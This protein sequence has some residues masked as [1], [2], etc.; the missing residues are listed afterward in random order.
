[1]ARIVIVDDSVADL[2]MMT[3][4]LE[5]GH[6]SVTA[7]NNPQEAAERITAQQPQLVM[8]DVVMPV[9]NGY[10]VLRQL[11]RNPATQ[12]IPVILVSSKGTE[13]D[14]RWGL[15]QGASAYVTKP[16]TAEDVLTTIAQVT[17]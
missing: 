16:Y 3:S 12:G 10:D 4:I 7:L 17:G 1:M 6:H 5:A 15:R 13:T 14:V 8:L 9:K 2:K 11:K